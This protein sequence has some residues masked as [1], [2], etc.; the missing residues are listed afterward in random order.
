MESD[1]IEKKIS[2]SERTGM[3]RTMMITISIED[4]S[5]N[6]YI[7]ETREKALPHIKEIELP[8]LL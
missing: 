8:L 2:E 1:I 5:G 6:T 7:E 4:E 3:S